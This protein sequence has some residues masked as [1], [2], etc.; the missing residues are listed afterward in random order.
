MWLHYPLINW[1]LNVLLLW[2][3]HNLH[4][5]DNFQSTIQF[6]M[7]TMCLDF[8]LMLDDVLHVTLMHLYRHSKVYIII[9]NF[10]VDLLSIYIPHL[11]C[12]LGAF[13]KIYSSAK[14]YCIFEIVTY[15]N[16]II[17]ND[18][19]IHWKWSDLYIVS[20]KGLV[21]SLLVLAEV[22]VINSTQ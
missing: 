20:Y 11:S 14:Y 10:Y 21:F 6:T 8:N 5:R 17:D 19:Y 13:F 1:V 3:T 22:S 7:Y 4:V 15:M 9:N 16:F 18:Y 2:A 12:L